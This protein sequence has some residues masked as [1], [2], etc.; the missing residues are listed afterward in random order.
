[1]YQALC[2]VLE[3]WTMQNC[4]FVCLLIRISVGAMFSELEDPHKSLSG[5]LSPIP[6]EANSGGLSSSLVA[7]RFIEHTADYRT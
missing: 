5:S 2:Q 3:Y 7:T 4:F 1:M 6:Q